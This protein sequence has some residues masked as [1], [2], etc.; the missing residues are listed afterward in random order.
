[1]MSSKLNYFFCPTSSPRPKDSYLFII[2]NDK[3][4]QQVFALNS[5][6]QEMFDILTLEKDW[7][8]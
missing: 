6:N 2:I 5:W 8:N 1:M 4:K 7:N 3:E